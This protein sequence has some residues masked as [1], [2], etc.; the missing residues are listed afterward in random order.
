MR[1]WRCSRAS[2]CGLLLS[3]ASW[4]QGAE[5][6]EV[7]SQGSELSTITVTA[8]R[9]PE[10]VELIPA[11]LAVVSGDQVRARDGQ[12]LASALALVSGVEAPAGGDAGP[13]SAVPAFWGL[14][15][16][17]AFLL[18]M[19]QVPWGGAFN[20]AISTLN[21]T[22]VERIEV[23]KG[24]APV[25]Y[26]ATSFVGVVHVLHYPAGQ[27]SDTA[28]LALGNHGSARGSAAFALPEWQGYRESIAAESE[29]LG[30]ADKR[31][32]VADG[33]LLYRG[34]LNVG[35]GELR[36]DANA[37]I[38]RDTPP[39]PVIRERNALTAL[40]PIN[41]NFNPADAAINEDKYQLAVGYT[42]PTSSF[43]TW[44]TLASLAHS[45][46]D[47]VRAFLHPDLSGAADTQN[48]HR[49][50]LDDYLDTHLANA[51]GASSLVVG[52]DLLY[53]Y[54]RQSTANGNS[55]YTVPLDGTVMPPPTTHLPANEYGYVADKR[56]FTGQYVQL[57][58]KPSPRWD[59]TAGVRLNETQERKLSSDLSLPPFTPTQQFDAENDSRHQTRPAE[60][61]GLSFRVWGQ[62]DDQLVLYADVRNA[63]KPSALD[64]GPDYQPAVLLPE[65]AK[66]YEAGLRGAAAEGRVTYGAE[67]FRLDF[68][69]LVVPTDSGFLTNAAG[70]QLQGVEVDARFNVDADFALLANYTYHN[71]RFTHY[72]FFDGNANAYVEVAGKQLPLS[73]RQLAA[74]GIL[75]SPR[76]GFNSTLIAN[77][78]G[79]RFLDEENVAPVGGYTKLDM[80]VGY[81]FGHYQLALEGTNL[82]NQRPPVSASEFGS[83]S[84]YLL[85]AR[86]LWIRLTYRRHP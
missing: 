46:V 70:E 61:L 5:R 55:A 66:M 65:T 58:W 7:A 39:S 1:S 80:T 23:L 13:S 11:S 17:D 86:S 8:T 26:G 57:D 24:A 72:E 12:D 49:L 32:S 34:A 44:D 29:S 54:G 21:F 84:F 64:F 9:I 40:T 59:L 27:A 74:V 43:G 62:G 42:L 28:D 3:I 56:L 69:N 48:Q 77:Y 53:G 75:Y 16:F 73:P 19:D 38:V 63:F 78:D 82:T 31:E 37:S 20:P 41:A 68:K 33:R 85:N 6:S 2:L 71:A 76:E 14:H 22:D 60:T 81:A 36:V 67:A 35:G 30:F 79:R 25:M 52:A 47:D 50:I 51:F 83:A 4:A 18:V 45:H 15:E 10:P